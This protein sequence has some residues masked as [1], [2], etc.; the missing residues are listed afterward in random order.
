ME[1]EECDRARKVPHA[2]LGVLEAPCGVEAETES[3][4]MIQGGFV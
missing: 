1:E 2:Q 3:T 4:G